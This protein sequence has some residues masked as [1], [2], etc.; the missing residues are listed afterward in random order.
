MEQLKWVRLITRV[1]KERLANRGSFRE[2][3]GLETLV[4]ARNITNR[5]C[6][7]PANVL[8]TAKSPRDEPNES[9]TWSPGMMAPEMD[10]DGRLEVSNLLTA[11]QRGRA[12][13]AHTAKR[14]LKNRDYQSRLCTGKE[15]T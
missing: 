9:P 14:R 11:T 3:V 1:F 6:R 7:D 12:T 2:F 5:R 15:L 13:R 4:W 10:S 8:V